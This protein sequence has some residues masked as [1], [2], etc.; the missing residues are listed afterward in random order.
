MLKPPGANIGLQRNVDRG[1]FRRDLALFVER[2][3]ELRL[4]ERS[5][6]R[7]GEGARGLL[8]AL[9]VLELNLDGIDRL[10]VLPLR[11]D[12]REA[13]LDPGN[14]LVDER[15]RLGECAFVE[16]IQRA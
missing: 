11:L 2:V 12:V 1:R 5:G 15:P 14:R 9:D 13:L 8:R 3:A 7:L 6:L 4:R 10:A 16:P